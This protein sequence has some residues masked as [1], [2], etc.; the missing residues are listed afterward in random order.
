MSFPGPIF[1]ITRHQIYFYYVVTRILSVSRERQV[2]NCHILCSLYGP[3]CQF[4]HDIDIYLL[5]TVSFDL[6]LQA[7]SF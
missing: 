4:V 7:A 6:R 2:N 5:V 1:M 3:V